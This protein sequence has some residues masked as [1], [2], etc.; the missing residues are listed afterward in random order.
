MYLTRAQA[1]LIEE[2]HEFTNVV[3][4][5]TKQSKMGCAEFMLRVL[6]HFGSLASY[7]KGIHEHNGA[8][9]GQFND[10][11]RTR[12]FL[13]LS[14]EHPGL[15]RILDA[16]ME[17]LGSEN[18]TLA[19]TCTKDE[20]LSSTAVEDRPILV[21]Q[22][23]Q[24]PHRL[25]ILS[26][27]FPKWVNQEIDSYFQNAGASD[28]RF[29]ALQRWLVRAV[30]PSNLEHLTGSH[31]A[32][33]E[34]FCR[35]SMQKTMDAV[36]AVDMSLEDPRRFLVLGAVPTAGECLTR[37]EKVLAFFASNVYLYK[38]SEEATKD[39]TAVATVYTE[40][41]RACGE[42][43]PDMMSRH[44]VEVLRKQMSWLSETSDGYLAELPNTLAQHLAMQM[45]E[46]VSARSKGLKTPNPLSDSLPEALDFLHLK[47]RPLHHLLES[48]GLS[49]AIIL[50][51]AMSAQG[52]CHVENE[53]DALVKIIAKMPGL[54]GLVDVTMLWTYGILRMAGVDRLLELP[55]P[56]ADHF[57]LYLAF[58]D[59]RLRDGIVDDC[60]L[61]SVLVHELGL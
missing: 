33:V 29:M 52:D 20:Y 14:F 24:I 46:M 13:A 59:K 10:I 9:V 55:L 3:D 18:T 50:A 4:T 23:L 39:A 57:K 60:V 6:E 16:F 38:A 41:V 27:V 19:T 61:E 44:L 48:L 1:N 40:I 45:Q 35:L 12:L 21:G 22:N 36:H 8:F 30:R 2:L 15:D 43:S 42:L 28:Q 7:Y 25:E 11:A 34:T 49:P 31:Q 51:N 32:V 47:Y 54:K 26:W 17:D 56:D 58:D 53:T 5:L 37:I